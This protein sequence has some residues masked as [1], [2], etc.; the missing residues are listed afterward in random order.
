M[1]SKT[2]K[3]V[4]GVAVI[5]V[6]GV[7]TAFYVN[8]RM[9][10]K[11]MNEKLLGVIDKDQGSMEI[12]LKIPGSE[13]SYDEAFSLCDKCLNDRIELIIN[14][15]G[16]NPDMK[17]ELKDSITDFLSLEN[18]LVRDLKLMYSQ[19]MELHT[20]I[21]SITR[22][23]NSDYSYL[24]KSDIRSDIDE[25]KDLATQ[26]LRSVS[27]FKEKYATLMRNEANIAKQ[28]DKASLRFTQIFGKYQ[29]GNFAFTDMLTTGCQGVL[30][31]GKKTE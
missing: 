18:E 24:Y 23:I 21:E 13:T 7:V 4:A 5:I 8:H 26:G 14:L 25:A 3:I 20:K 31:Y 19:D 2:V 1:T 15:R 28:M 30:D 10:I 11:D 17:S 6:V 27:S 16:I 12:T 22:L 29:T 9:K